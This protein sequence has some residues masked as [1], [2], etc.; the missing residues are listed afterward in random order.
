[1]TND[2]LRETAAAVLGGA[3]VMCAMTIAQ[4]LD[5]RDAARENEH[6][7][8]EAARA[9]FN[10]GISRLRCVAGMR[11]DV[12]AGEFVDVHAAGPRR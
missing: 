9:G 10:E 2:K 12:A 6:L 1:M 3:F 8:A 7:R 4:V 5:A 11:Y